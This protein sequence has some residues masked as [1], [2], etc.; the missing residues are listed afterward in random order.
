MHMVRL[1]GCYNNYHAQAAEALRGP[2]YLLPLEEVASRVAEAA[3]R[4]ATEVSMV[5]S[6]GETGMS[7]T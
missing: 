5:V 3:A 1:A 6:D 2:A 4:G 7:N